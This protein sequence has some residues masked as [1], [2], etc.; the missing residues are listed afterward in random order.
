MQC[1]LLPSHLGQG[2]VCFA[3]KCRANSVG[4]KTAIERKGT[5]PNARVSVAPRASPVCVVTASRKL[6]QIKAMSVRIQNI[7]EKE[8]NKGLC[9]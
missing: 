3:R 8:G 9:C 1:W 2:F 7:E 4:T 6:R 5:V